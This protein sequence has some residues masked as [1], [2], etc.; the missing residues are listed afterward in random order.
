MSAEDFSRYR[1]EAEKQLS[2]IGEAENYL[3]HYFSEEGQLKIFI[4]GGSSLTADLATGEAVYESIRRRP[5]LSSLD[6][7]NYNP[8]RWWTF[9]RTFSWGASLSSSSR[10]W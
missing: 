7:L 2:A 9:F 4:R 10:G 3:K 8:S 6:R 1:E 5:L